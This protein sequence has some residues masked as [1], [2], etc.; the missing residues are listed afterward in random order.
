MKLNIAIGLVAF[1][2]SS[3]INALLATDYTAV[4]K[5]GKIQLIHL[6][7]LTRGH[8]RTWHPH[9]ATV[10]GPMVESVSHWR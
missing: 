2:Y 3:Y 6:D 4:I 5:F 9:C 1:D 7:R 10:V 8:N